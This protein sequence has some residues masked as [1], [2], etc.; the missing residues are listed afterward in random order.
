MTRRERL[1]M[2]IAGIITD[3]GSIETSYGFPGFALTFGVSLGLSGYELGA[4]HGT[5]GALPAYDGLW[6]SK[7]FK[8]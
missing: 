3:W 4:R 7:S 8:K 1:E 2:V 6:A 5:G